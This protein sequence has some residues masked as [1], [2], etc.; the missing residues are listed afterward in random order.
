MSRAVLSAGSN[1]GDSLGHLRSVVEGFADELVAVS[2]VYATPPWGGIEQGDFLNITLI[3]DG[4][5]S[6]RQWLDRGNGLEQAADRTREVRWGPRTLD[7]DVISVTESG[8]VVVDDDPVL[9]L[10]HPR[11]A[12]RA[13]VLIPWLEIEPEA[14]LWTPEGERPV[15]DLVDALDAAERDAVRAVERIGP[16]GGG[17]S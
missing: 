10:P 6:A 9:T 16:A 14:T 4:P 8:R 1:V 17:A 3:V 7:V 12:Q 13:F 11:A 5:S 2:A 15:R